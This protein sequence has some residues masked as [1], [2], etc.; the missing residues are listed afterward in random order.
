MEFIIP[1]HD[2]GTLS[3]RVADPKKMLAESADRLARLKALEPEQLPMA[4]AFLIGYHPRVFDAMLAAVEPCRPLAAADEPLA[5]EPYCVKCDAPVGIFL[6]HGKDYRHYRGVV[7]ATSKP[8]P[9]KA[10]HKPVIGW[11]PATDVFAMAG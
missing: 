2:Q 10:D 11:R 7:T 8:R 1:Q 4:L 6:A 5:Q 9:Y 3:L